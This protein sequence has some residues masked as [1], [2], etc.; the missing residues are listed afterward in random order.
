MNNTD[1]SHRGIQSILNS[2][3]ILASMLNTNKPPVVYAEPIVPK[4]PNY[5][6]EL[7]KNPMIGQLNDVNIK[8]DD[9]NH[10]QDA[11]I[12]ELQ[13]ANQKHDDVIVELQN[14]NKKHDADIKD[15]TNAIKNQKRINW[16]MVGLTILLF[17]LTLGMFL[18]MIVQMNRPVA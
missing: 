17:L 13:N 9:A 10:K 14:A 6:Y 11:V 5:L 15:N 18:I 2:D 8:L 12:G 4:T 3:R 1:E 7:A 16:I